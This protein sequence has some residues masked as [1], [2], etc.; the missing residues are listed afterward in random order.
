MTVSFG[1]YELGKRIFLYISLVQ[2]IQVPPAAPKVIPSI[3]K[4]I[5]SI[6]GFY[7]A[8]KRLEASDFQQLGVSLF[9]FLSDNIFRIAVSSGF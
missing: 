3:D 9:H 8:Q 5:L 4:S 2:S 7:F 1:L 6:D